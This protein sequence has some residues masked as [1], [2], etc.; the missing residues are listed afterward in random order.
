VTV[1]AS[2]R[3]TGVSETLL[4][5]ARPSS[6]NSYWAA[7]YLPQNGSVYLASHPAKLPVVVSVKVWRLRLPLP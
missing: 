1:S 2:V 7:V 6:A 5:A 4:F 3:A